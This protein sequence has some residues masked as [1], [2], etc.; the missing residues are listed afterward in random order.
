MDSLEDVTKNYVSIS[1]SIDA[2]S[3]YNL[4]DRTYEAVI[5]AF[6]EYTAL[7]NQIQSPSGSYTSFSSATDGMLSNITKA[8]T[9]LKIAAGI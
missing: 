4:D 9:S 5:N 2:L 3:S 6:S 7:F 1:A 8:I